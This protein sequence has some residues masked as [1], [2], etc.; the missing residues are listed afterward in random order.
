MHVARDGD[1]FYLAAAELDNPTAGEQFQDVARQDGMLPPLMALNDLGR[2]CSL[3]FP[4]S[5]G[6]QRSG[7]RVPVVVARSVSARAWWLRRR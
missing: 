5:G 3:I 2:S 1:Q 4:T 6:G 7:W